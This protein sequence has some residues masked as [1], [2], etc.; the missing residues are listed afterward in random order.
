MSYDVEPFKNNSTS[1]SANDN[2]SLDKIDRTEE[3]TNF[4]RTQQYLP[5]RPTVEVHNQLEDAFD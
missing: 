4:N 1:Q 3:K 5:S 2:T